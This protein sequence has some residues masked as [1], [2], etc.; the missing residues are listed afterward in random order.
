ML[1]LQLQIFQSK[2]WMLSILSLLVVVEAALPLEAV[3]V[4]VVIEQQHLQDWQRL[5]TTA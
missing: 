5:Q 2:H 1:L 4:P 3:E